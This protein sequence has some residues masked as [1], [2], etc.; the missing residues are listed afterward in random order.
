MIAQ[1]RVRTREFLKKRRIGPYDR[2]R[3]IPCAD[4]RQARACE[5]HELGGLELP[6]DADRGF[7]AFLEPARAFTALGEI[8]S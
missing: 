1:D 4:K 5:I 7:T 3:K 8:N 2:L 6:L